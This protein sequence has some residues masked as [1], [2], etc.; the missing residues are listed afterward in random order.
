MDRNRE[1]SMQP[2]LP[3]IGDRVTLKPPGGNVRMLA[4]MDDRGTVEKVNAKTI[5]VRFDT[6]HTRNMSPA[7]FWLD[8]WLI[9]QGVSR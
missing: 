9:E 1:D 5:R 4:V 3:T 2:S 6:G 8:S 7:A